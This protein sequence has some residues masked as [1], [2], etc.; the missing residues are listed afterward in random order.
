[1]R[2]NAFAL[3]RL[4]VGA[5]LVFGATQVVASG[6]A[7]AATAVTINGAG[8][9]SGSTF[10]YSPA[11]A[12]AASGDTITWTNQSGTAHTVTRCDPAACSGT[13]G[14]TGTDPAF[15]HSVASNNGATA[16]QTLNGAG[17]YNYYCKIHGFAVMHGTVTVQGQT[18]A[19]TTTSASSSTTPSTTPATTTTTKAP[20]APPASAVSGQ[21]NFTG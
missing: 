10:C 20:A 5:A 1:M 6:P 21:V 18:A 7:H 15:D 9:C 2:R 13:D 11:S 14:G 16:S 19:T 3:F 8:A 17:T 12:S 4:A